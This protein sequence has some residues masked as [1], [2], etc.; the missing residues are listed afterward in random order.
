VQVIEPPITVVIESWPIGYTTLVGI[1]QK[2]DSGAVRVRPGM[3]LGL[4][5]PAQAAAV[6]VKLVP[7]VGKICKNSTY[8]SLKL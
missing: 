6:G 8:M 4:V 2:Y 7:E 5:S 3:R 1:S